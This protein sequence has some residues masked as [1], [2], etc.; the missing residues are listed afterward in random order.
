[1]AR[2]ISRVRVP[3]S[4]T[5]QK[6][7]MLSIQPALFDVSKEGEKYQTSEAVRGLSALGTG[8]SWK[9]MGKM[10]LNGKEVEEY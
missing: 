7:D 2:R 6:G 3:S 8:S 10:Y 9:T 1:M 4:Y 5:L